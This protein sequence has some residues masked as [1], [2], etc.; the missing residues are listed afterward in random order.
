MNSWVLQNEAKNIIW[1]RNI[2]DNL[3]QECEGCYYNNPANCIDEFMKPTCQYK[4]MADVYI[5]SLYRKCPAAL[6]LFNL[7]CN[8]RK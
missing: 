6:S 3:L 4:E 5:D 8:K 2:K 7:S 1:I